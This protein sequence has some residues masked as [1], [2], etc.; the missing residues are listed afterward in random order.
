M[1]QG[2]IY[3]KQFYIVIPYYIGEN[4]TDQVK[5]VRWDKFLD[6]L[7]S[8]D[9]VETIVG[10]YRNFV[11]GQKLIDTRVNLIQEGLAGM[12]IQTKQLSTKEVISLLFSMYN[13]LLDST[14]A[15]TA[16]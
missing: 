3:I 11:K 7:N 9:D 14:Q 5:K 12:G 2:L 6:T 16:L 8:K 15:Q 13:P 10:R 1:K 4:D